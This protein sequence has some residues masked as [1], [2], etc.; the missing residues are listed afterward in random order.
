MVKN[1]CGCNNPYFCRSMTWLARH[2]VNSY[3][4]LKWSVLLI[5]RK[6]TINYTCGGL[7]L[8][9]HR[10]S[11]HCK[12]VQIGKNARWQWGYKYFR[13]FRIP[14]WFFCNCNR[15]KYCFPDLETRKKVRQIA[16]SYWHASNIICSWH[17]HDWLLNSNRKRNPGHKL[18]EISKIIYPDRME[19]KKKSAHNW[20]QNLYHETLKG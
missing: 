1:H 6:I 18:K 3:I 9:A 7:E 12:H 13:T 16:L 10:T 5:C 11:Q 17:L 19:F 20:I 15:N 2:P 8:R 4:N 14:C